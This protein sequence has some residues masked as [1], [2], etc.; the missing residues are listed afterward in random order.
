MGNQILQ[1]SVSLSLVSAD[2]EVANKPQKVLLV[3]QFIA[4]TAT[5]GV[6]VEDIAND[7]SENGLFQRDSHLAEMVRA[8]KRIAPQ[9]QLDAIPL[10]D[11]AG[12][13]AI[14]S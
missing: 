2:L 1:P 12:Q 11:A 8:F 5:D 9:V 7:G 4:G 10:A 14:K 6:L 13:A 3:G